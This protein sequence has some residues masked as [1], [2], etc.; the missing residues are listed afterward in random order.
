MSWMEDHWQELGDDALIKDNW[1]ELEDIKEV[2]QPLKTCT[3]NT[4]GRAAGP[5]MLLPCK[6]NIRLLRLQGGDM[7]GPPSLQVLVAL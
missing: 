2:L 7:S 4:E 5:L 6:S 3:K 1:Q